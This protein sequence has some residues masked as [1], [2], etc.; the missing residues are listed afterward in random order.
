MS[1]KKLSASLEKHEIENN[2]L[3]VDETYR[4]YF[5]QY[6]SYVIT[7][8]A[9]PALTDGLKPVQRRILHALWENEDG[10]YNKVANL[11]GHCMKYHPH[12][13]ASIFSALVGLGQKKLLIDTQGNWGDPVTSDP[14]AAPRYIEARLTRFAKEVL[15]A[16]HLTDFKMTYDGR[17]KEPIALP[18]RFP[19]LLALG[20]EGIAV[21]LTTRILPHNF[22]ELIEAEKAYLRGED[23]Q[24]FPDFPTGALIDI[25]D[26][27]DGL[28]GSRVKIRAVL[29][30]TGKSVKIKEVPYGVSTESLI[31]SILAASEKGKIKVSN[32][33]D[34]SAAEIEIIVTFQRGV[35][36][37]NAEQALYAF[38]DC[39][40]SLSSTSTVIG[41]NEP[42][43]LSV[44]EILIASTERTR[45]LLKRD[46]EY[47]LEKLEQKWHLKSLVQIFVEN[48]IYLRIEKADTREKVFSEIRTGLEPHLA[49]L[50]REVTEEDI[51]YLTEVRIRRI[52]AWDA[53][54]AREELLK[55]DEEII[56]VK[57]FLDNITDYTIAYLDHL[58]ED[59][60]EGT[61]RRSK[62]TSFDSIQA[63]AVAERTS[64]LQVNR[65]GGFVGTELKDAEEVGSC[66]ALDEVLTVTQDG[67]L[68]ISKVADRKYVGEHIV[69][70]QLFPPESRED[71]FNMLYEDTRSG[72]VYL[73]RFQVGG[74][75]RDKRYELGK[76]KGHTRI[77]LFIPGKDELFAHLKLRKKPRIKTDV[78]LQFSDYLVKS[79][80]AAGVT[81]SRHKP[82][83]A[84]QISATVFENRT[85][86]E[87]SDEEKAGDTDKLPGFE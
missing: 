85:G 66:S 70:V 2:P 78:Y 37:E 45:E 12:G 47:Q 82:S 9:I 44:S 27:S 64:K 67:G 38:T 73:K 81:V 14:P 75:T 17:N 8:R 36:M 11:V 5:L 7:D 79:R 35:D 86:S 34:N 26:Y 84:R 32:I 54:Q 16:P 53:E 31:D 76:A 30:S 60:G 19:L 29:E 58:L 18:V 40:V 20:A 43:T 83:S 15:F 65:K 57:L 28:P 23:F 69:H 55:I 63:V 49:N 51:E 1:K 72:R 10:R 59:Y 24:L 61:E 80:G 21:G 62:I 6:A 42:V 25:E 22:R 71:V 77:L 48:R 46:L 52:S 56:K 33:Q 13:D 50:R 68:I 3:N 4:E 87:S 39:E 41:K 74:Y